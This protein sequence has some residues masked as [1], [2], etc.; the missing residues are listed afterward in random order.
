MKYL[1]VIFYLFFLSSCS[2]EEI[3]ESIIPKVES[4]FAQDYL[5]KLRAK[6]YEFLKSHMRPELLEKV[7]LDILDQLY[8]YFP[9]GELIS[10]ELIGSN[11]RVFNDEWSATFSFESK[12]SNGWSTS[13]V[14]MLKE[15][16]TLLVTRINVY[17]IPDSQKVLT[18]FDNGKVTFITVLIL[19]L[20]FVSPILMIVTCISVYRTDILNKWRWYLL[21]FVGLCSFSLN[22]TTGEVFT[23]VATIKLLGF[24][25]GA[26]SEYAPF[27][28]AFTFPIGAIMYWSKRT[29]LI[30]TSMANKSLKQDK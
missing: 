10:T 23:K 1:L 21:S 7:D 30:E 24:S 2:N 14:S 25:A 8:S 26:A 19:I 28:F 12:Y 15:K 9:T 5:D 17:Q 22:W 3:K 11:V 6:D 18:S 13:S 20:T 27:I 29:Q 16:D 4:K